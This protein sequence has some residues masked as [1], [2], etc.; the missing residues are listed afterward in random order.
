MCTVLFLIHKI[1]IIY[2][3][4]KDIVKMRYTENSET[5]NGYDFKT[6]SVTFTD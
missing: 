3:F 1:D 5:P 4:H 2:L 6:E